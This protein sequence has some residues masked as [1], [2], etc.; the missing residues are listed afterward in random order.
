MG[1]G[2][3]DGMSRIW[4]SQSLVIAKWGTGIMRKRARGA[5]GAVGADI[6]V[7]LTRQAIVD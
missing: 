4:N 1:E 2:V 6:T 5:N 3:G 7:I